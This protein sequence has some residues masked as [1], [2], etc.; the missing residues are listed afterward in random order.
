[1]V[2]GGVFG[3]IEEIAKHAPS[4]MDYVELD[5]SILKLDSHLF[6]SL[7]RPEVEA[8]VGDGRLFIKRSGGK[9]NVIIVDLPDPENAQINRFYTREFFEE[10]QKALEP[11]GVLYFS[12][13][14]A[15][16]YLEKGGLALNRTVYQALSK[17]FSH[18]TVFPGIT[19]FFLASE[20]PAE[21]DIPA[22][23][24]KRGVETRQLVDIDLATMADPFRMDNLA[25]LLTETEVRPNRDLSPW[26]FG[27]ML[28]LWMTKSKSSQW[29][30]WGVTGIVLSLAAAAGFRDRIRF[31]IMTSG[32]AGMGMELALVL[33]F[34]VVYGYAYTVLCLFITLFMIGA[35]GGG[36]L[37]L[38]DEKNAAKRYKD[39]ET[40]TYGGGLAGA[41]MRTCVRS[42]GQCVGSIS[43]GLHC[44]TPAD[45]NLGLV[46]RG[47]V[48]CGI[49]I[50]FRT[51][52]AD[53]GKSLLGRLG[54]R[55][56][57][58]PCHGADPPSQAGNPGGAGLFAGG[59]I[60]VLAP[61]LEM[62]LRPDTILTALPFSVVKQF[63]AVRAPFPRC[64]WAG[65]SRKC[66]PCQSDRP[67]S[68][69]FNGLCFLS[70]LD[71][72]LHPMV[73]AI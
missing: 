32:F 67:L 72:F 4:R 30:F 44:F 26:A 70:K 49:Q 19:H 23:L 9:Y 69:S 48:R 20:S 45:Y 47:A 25:S 21:L 3:S 7:E 39:G 8:H 28:D 56:L 46:C 5:K 60:L 11:G 27:H 24:A 1:M 15:D 42:C 16:N 68:V 36:Y 73:N 12:L 22:V 43:C 38:V 57:R 31:T 35:A 65:R 52:S 14:G 10:A 64:I 17:V 34:Q 63:P 33:L 53:H 66:I 2:A 29:L 54:G 59:Q 62:L 18:V 50:V 13:A 55:V 6:H 40:G 37:F 58:L 71:C 51:R 61:Q 41:G